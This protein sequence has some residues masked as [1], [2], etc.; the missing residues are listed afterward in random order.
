MI[1]VGTVPEK[2]LRPLGGED[3]FWLFSLYF[4]RKM[5]LLSGGKLFLVNKILWAENVVKGLT[6]YKFVP[7]YP[8]SPLFSY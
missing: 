6:Q 1:S 5:R 2:L 4:G 8:V 7:T 3:F